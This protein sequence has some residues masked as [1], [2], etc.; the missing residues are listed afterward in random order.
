LGLTNLQELAVSIQ[1]TWVKKAL[2]NQNDV[3]KYDLKSITNNFLT[4]KINNEAGVLANFLGSFVKFCEI[5]DGINNNFLKSIILDNIN[6]CYGRKLE[7]KFDLNFF[8]ELATSEENLNEL[9]VLELRWVDLIDRN[10]CPKSNPEIAAVLNLNNRIAEAGYQKLKARYSIAKKK[11]FSEGSSVSGPKEYLLSGKNKGMSKKIRMLFT[12]SRKPELPGNKYKK[13]R[14]C[15]E[16][17]NVPD[18]NKLAT[19]WNL[20]W[21]KSYLMPEIRISYSDSTQ[22][23]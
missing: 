2:A 13:F 4:R 5:W 23:R 7:N 21:N 1:C 9:I 12:Q 6:F 14:E 10:Y 3:W 18:P 8:R 17:I 19:A 16:L 11:Y 15:A 22:I 20:S